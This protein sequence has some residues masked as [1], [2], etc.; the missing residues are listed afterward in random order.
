MKN[1]NDVDFD[2]NINRDMR[3]K[4]MFLL[5]DIKLRIVCEYISISCVL[6]SVSFM[7]MMM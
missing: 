1:V 7:R 2:T 4:V 3:M 5:I 6:L